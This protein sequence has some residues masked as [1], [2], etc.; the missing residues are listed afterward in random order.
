VF[1]GE[2]APYGRWIERGRYGWVWEPMRVPVGWRPYSRGRWVDTDYGWTW[3]SQEP[4][5]WATDHY[6]R[7]LLDPE[8]G[9]LWVPGTDWGPAWVSFQQGDGYIG[10]APLPP[11]VGFRLGIGIQ[12]GGL[13]LS[14]A[15][16]PYA[17]SFVPERNFLD[18]RLEG[19][20]VPP[21]RNVTLIRSTTNIT[22]F[23][24]DRDRVVNDSIPVQRI[25]QA[26]GQRVRRFQLNDSRTPAR[27]RVA[28]VQGDQVSIFRPAPRLGQARPDVTPSVV[29]QRRQQQAQ[30]RPVAPPPQG[31]SP[32]QPPQQPRQLPAPHLMPPQ[33][34]PSPAD[35]ERKHQAEQQQLQARQQAEQ[36]RLQQLEERD[37]A[38]R[39]AAQGQAQDRAA[40][41]Q[42]E[43]KALQDQHQREQQLLEA[44]HQRERQAAQARPQ[45]QKP[46]QQ[47]NQEQKNREREK[48]PEPPPPPP[49]V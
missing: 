15:I 35:L 45:G 6:G 18:E 20:F 8:Y 43:Q 7:W 27:G 1:Y 29:I 38:S 28:Q 23:R 37:N 41:H 19:D 12:I 17:Y 13:S 22:N 48:K 26:T 34:A 40:Q 44:R 32:G 33:P 9:W 31:Q 42:A 49:S 16:D 5:G 3:I 11:S 25:E 30:Q 46:P 2:L 47:Q 21:A 14:A 24:T 36:R 10:W 4:W 39:Q